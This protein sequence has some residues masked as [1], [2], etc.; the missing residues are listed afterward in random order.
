MRLIGEGKVQDNTQV[1]NFNGRGDGAA[2]HV[3][4]KIPNLLKQRLENHNHE[5]CF[6]AKFE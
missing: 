1:A 5:L 4:D 3:G 2:I 6:P